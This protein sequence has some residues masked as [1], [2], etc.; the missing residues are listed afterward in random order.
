MRW[1]QA[2]PR[3]SAAHQAVVARSATAVTEHEGLAVC[4]AWVAGNGLASV[5]PDAA[6]AARSLL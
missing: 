5:V 1:S 2:L 6:A 4:G 3:P